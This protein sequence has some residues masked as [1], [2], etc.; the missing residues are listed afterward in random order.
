MSK[1]AVVIDM[2]IQFIADLVV[3]FGV[4]FPEAQAANLAHKYK[5][6]RSGRKSTTDLGSLQYSGPY[7]PA[8]GHREH[9]EQL[10]A[11]CNSTN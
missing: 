2:H 9:A 1:M 8:D 3:L 5:S 7:V 6:S 11:S 10:R 4:Q